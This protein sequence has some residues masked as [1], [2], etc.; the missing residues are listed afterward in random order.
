MT[1][2]SRGELLQEFKHDVKWRREMHCR[3]TVLRIAG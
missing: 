1:K 2:T 3:D